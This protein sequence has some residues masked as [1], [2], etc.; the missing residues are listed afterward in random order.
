M[1]S[2]QDQPQGEETE[3]YSPSTIESR[4]Q[5][6]WAEKGLYQTS[7]SLGEA[8]NWFALTMFP[9]P[10]GDVHIGHWYAFAPADAHA[11]FMRMEGFNVMEPQGFDAFGLPA[12]NAAIRSRIHPRL[13]TLRNID[14]MRRQFPL[15]G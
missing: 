12:E 5:K 14:N 6:E 8:P 2:S 1:N 7:D 9:Y 11:R 4:W 3:G 10:S 13:W 15:Y